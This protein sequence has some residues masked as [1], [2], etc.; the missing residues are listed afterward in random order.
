MQCFLPSLMDVIS[1]TQIWA[2]I[3]FFNRDKNNVI[4]VVV[5]IYWFIIW[6]YEWWEEKKNYELKQ[7]NKTSIINK[8]RLRESTSITLLIHNSFPSH[9]SFE[10]KTPNHFIM[11]P[12]FVTLVSSCNVRYRSCVFVFLHGLYTFELP[13]IEWQI[14]WMQLFIRKWMRKKEGGRGVRE[15]TNC[16]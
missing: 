12:C 15:R 4:V 7:R 13:D 3:P 10:F 11:L 14:H 9:W 5:F 8:I 6:N 1:L 2:L 16:T